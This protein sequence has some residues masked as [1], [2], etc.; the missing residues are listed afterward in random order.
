MLVGFSGGLYE[1]FLGWHGHK[2]AAED[3]LAAA[4]ESF[5]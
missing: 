2:K 1:R 5:L 3:F 4:F